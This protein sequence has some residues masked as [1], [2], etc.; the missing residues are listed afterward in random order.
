MQTGSD[1]LLS[2]TDHRASG[3]R[4]NHLFFYLC[5]QMCVVEEVVCPT[6]SAVEH[7]KFNISGMHKVGTNSVPFANC[8]F[9]KPLLDQATTVPQWDTFMLHLC[10]ICS[11]RSSLLHVKWQLNGLHFFHN[12]TTHFS[13]PF[14]S[15]LSLPITLSFLFERFILPLWMATGV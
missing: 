3:V 2:H 6:T 1:V 13:L 10:S 11:M 9:L 5:V 7:H 15:I 4:F 12:I 14:F 8:L